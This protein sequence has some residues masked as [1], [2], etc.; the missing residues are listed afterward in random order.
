[1]EFPEISF[2]EF[3]NALYD[4]FDWNHE[5]KPGKPGKGTFTKALLLAGL[6]EDMDKKI[7]D[8][9][10]DS[11]NDTLLKYFHG[12]VKPSRVFM[13]TNG[14]YDP[15]LFKDFIHD[16]FG[17]RFK[18]IRQAFTK[19]NVSI[20]VGQEPFC[21]SQ[22]YSQIRFPSKQ[23]RCTISKEDAKDIKDIIT[24]LWHYIDKLVED[25]APYVQNE[26]RCARYK[27]DEE[28]FD[29]LN[30]RL[31]FYSLRYSQIELFVKAVR[32][33]YLLD[34][35]YTRRLNE[36]GKCFIGFDPKLSDYRHFLEQIAKLI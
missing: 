30:K 23:T 22:I 14:F 5:P 19:L 24:D 10:E 33:S 3:A 16:K 2:S 15:E 27:I 31:Y 28:M 35:K 7:Y 21:L 34:F 13:I 25:E 26:E 29:K 6:S 9:I 20:A 12:K 1:M 36:D 11:K 8:K 17:Q 4:F 18:E 32:L